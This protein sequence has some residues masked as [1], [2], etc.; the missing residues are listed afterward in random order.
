M[1]FSQK[2]QESLETGLSTVLPKIGS[3][4]RYLPATA[5]PAQSTSEGFCNPGPQICHSALQRTQSFQCGNSYNFIIFWGKYYF[6]HT[7]NKFILTCKIMINTKAMEK[8]LNACEHKSEN[9]AM[10]ISST[11]LNS[12]YFRYSLWWAPVFLSTR[13]ISHWTELAL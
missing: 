7:D 13:L 8:F 10:K 2:P 3:L 12:P 6:C 11:P 5:S 9:R 4:L 1:L